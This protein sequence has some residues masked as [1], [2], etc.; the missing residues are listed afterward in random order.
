MC[1][2]GRPRTGENAIVI[3]AGANML[4]G[5]E[6][7]QDAL[8]AISHTKVLVC[9]LEITPQTSLQAMRMAHDNKGESLCPP[10]VSEVRK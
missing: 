6:E 5:T 10:H 3:V 2:Y 9:Q 8:P 1:L 7:L 4:L